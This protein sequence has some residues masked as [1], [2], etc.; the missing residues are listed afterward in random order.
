MAF[1]YIGNSTKA[2]TGATEIDGNVP[3][4]VAAGDIIIGVYAFE[5]VAA[6]SGPWIIPNNG[7]LTSD[8]IGPSEGW[9][10][11]CWQA[12]S[13]SGVGIEVW[14]AIYSSGSFM[15]AQFAAS[16]NAVMAAAAYSGEYNPTGTIGGAPPRVATT[17]QVTGN[18]PAAPAVTANTGELIVA[19]GGDLTSGG[20][21]GT[22]SGFTSRV[23][24]DRS[25][26]GT[27]EAVIADRTATVAGGT[28]PITFPV[29]ASSSTTAG[30]T[31]TLLI[32]PVPAAGGSGG[33]ID[34]PLPENLDIADGYTIRVTALNPVTG[35]VVSGVTIGT[36]VIT[37]DILGG[38]S[39][40]GITTGD[41]FLVPGPGA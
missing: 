10:Q 35:A 7:Q 15:K 3:A 41:W 22:P 9:Q 29:N 30:S 28:G 14:G 1:S 23:D 25:G 32:T 40:G 21:F 20:S 12:P 11:L 8:F 18:N 37:A 33:I 17:A 6:G 36:S 39:D 38:P 4:A 31:A 2:A 34:V 24:V 5:G 26:A 13:A 16:Q 27:V 19:V